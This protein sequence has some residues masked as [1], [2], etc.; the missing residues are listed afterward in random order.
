MQ[1][2]Y[3]GDMWSINVL[4]RILDE[5]VRRSTAM[6]ANLLSDAPTR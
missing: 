6:L 5:E 3:T 4:G 1:L 2:E